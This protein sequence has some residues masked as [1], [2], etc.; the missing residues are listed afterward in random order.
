MITLAEP[1]VVRGRNGADIGRILL[2][3]RR[4]RRR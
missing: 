3:Q 2:S 1:T 4:F